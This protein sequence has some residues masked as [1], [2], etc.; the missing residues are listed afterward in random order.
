MS[1]VFYSSVAGNLMYAMVCTRPDLSLAVG[2]MSR[3]I[4]NR[5]KYHWEARKCIICYVKGSL[6]RC[7]VF[8]KSKTSTYDVVGFID[9]DYDGDLDRRHSIS[10]Y[11]FTLCT[12]AIS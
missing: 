7:L 8:N 12:G 3:Y 5:S 11:I 6:D 10:D 9:F 1:H 2:T 4:H